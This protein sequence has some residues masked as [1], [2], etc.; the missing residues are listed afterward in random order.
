MR[1]LRSAFLFAALIPPALAV[2]RVEVSPEGKSLAL[3]LEEVSI[4]L[5]RSGVPEGGV[6]IEVAP[7]EYFFDRRH[8]LG[9]EFQ[10]SADAPIILRARE[11]GTVWFKGSRPIDPLAFKPVTNPTER[12]LLA[13][14][15]RDRI[16]ATT[17]TD[18]VLISR[19]GRKLMLNLI[20]D[21]RSCLPSVFPNSGYAYLKENPV[22]AEISPPAIAPKNVN[23]GV[24]AGHPPQ[25]E[26]GCPLGWK[27]SLT[28]P[29]GARVGFGRRGDEM[30][31]TW[32]QWEA[33]LKRNNTRNTLTG[34]I[35]AN[36]LLSSQPIH[37]ASGDEKCIHLSR[38]LTYGWKWRQNDKPFRV[39]GMLCEL[40]QPGEWHFD[41]ATNRLYLI[42]FEPLNE[43]SEVALSVADGFLRLNDAE[44]VSIQGLS[45]RNVGS[46]SI[47]EITGRN[48]LVAGAVLR[49]ST[50]TGVRVDGWNNTV[51]GC[52]LVDLDSHVA[53]SGGVRTS[54]KITPAGNVVTNCHIYQKN[55]RHRKVNISVRGVGNRFANNLVH[56]S[57]GQAMTIGGNDHLIE[58][59]EMFNIGFD[60]G[61]GGA[62]Y[63]GGD[64][65]G[66][67]VI[68]RHN[69]FHHLM[70][71]P[72][73][74]ERSGIHLDDLQAGAICTGNIF[75]KSAAKG[76]HMNGGAGHVLTDNV[77]LEG[78]RG[79]YNVGRG[80]R[81]NYERQL[82]ISADPKSPKKLT[83]E[84]YVGRAER[85]VGPN[86][87]NKEPWKSRYP[88]FATVMNKEG[89]FGRLWPVHC[90][91]E[92]NL[93]FGNRVNHSLWSRCPP[94]VMATVVIRND[95]ETSPSDFVDYDRLDL[96]FTK[97]GLPA[98]PFERIG[99]R[100]DQDRRS[101]P[102]KSHYR[103]EVKKFFDGIKSMPGTTRKL[104][105]AAIVEA[106]VVR[107]GK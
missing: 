100:L 57:I 12:N 48:N 66:Y 28:E 80:G 44:H 49:D 74:V 95:R 26:P 17:L 86:G 18:P 56:N 15:A 81:T 13:P 22:T 16:V 59:N 21:G 68:Y 39:F 29:R 30:A 73:K 104:D 1:F 102:D 58:Q 65:T 19:L 105:T 60:E 97:E 84:D 89:R 75:Y 34:F 101:M 106:R 63:A 5:R 71:V 51:T 77:F 8:D 32:L 55:V 85:L 35:E 38:A 2:L 31:G 98:I 72:G 46:G 20:L 61:D 94:E 23:Y 90:T 9:K 92:N 37:A 79:A 47:Y 54:D 70:H 11:P 40:D 14:S 52:D 107:R 41:P 10:G 36:W 7:G 50:A 87:W 42:P 96:R 6:V 88:L 69:F 93:Y 67:G 24:R 45:V 76:I 91:V 43:E 4:M 99:L 64:L 25:Q 53:L 103:N 27:G 83:K 3:A 78:D 62:M 82:R 33:E